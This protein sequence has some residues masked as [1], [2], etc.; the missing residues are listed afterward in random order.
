M[1]KKLTDWRKRFGAAKPPHVVTLHT[2]FAG[3]KAGSTMLI[4]GGHRRVPRQDPAR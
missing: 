3:V 1:A 2:D 4:A